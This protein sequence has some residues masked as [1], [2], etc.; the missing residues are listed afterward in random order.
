MIPID[1]LHNYLNKGGPDVAKDYVFHIPEKVIAEGHI[2]DKYILDAKYSF[3]DKEIVDV[4]EWTGLDSSFK[5]IKDRNNERKNSFIYSVLNEVLGEF[6]YLDVKSK[7]RMIKDLM[8]QIAYDMEEKSLYRDND[9]TRKR[10]LIREKF[11][12]NED[13]DDDP[14][15]KGIIVD[16]FSLTVYVFRE[17]VG[18]L[19]KRRKVERISYIPSMWKNDDRK[20]EYVLKNPSCF[21]IE[22]EGRYYPV[23]KSDMTGVMSWESMGIEFFEE[24]R[25][26]GAVAQ[27]KQETKLLK[28]MTL[29]ELQ[30]VAIDRAVSIF[31]KSEK[32]GKDLKKSISELREELENM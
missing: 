18:G 27:P 32:T 11:M 8:R 25:S 28:K 20:M 30:K 4:P 10:T 16:Y 14:V 6:R 19:V 17:V 26:G 22:K 21:L 13:I 3:V 5:M 31:K 15:L 1:K 9:Y 12:A 2:Y 7:V 23:F 29:V 24:L